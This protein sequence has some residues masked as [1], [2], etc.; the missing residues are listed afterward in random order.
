MNRRATGKV[1]GCISVFAS[2]FAFISSYDAA[3]QSVVETQIFPSSNQYNKIDP[4]TLEL[5]LPE[6]AKQLIRF[7]QNER[8]LREEADLQGL[9]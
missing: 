7:P 4:K 3:R 1:I 8:Q 5:S 6:G 9:T 2:V